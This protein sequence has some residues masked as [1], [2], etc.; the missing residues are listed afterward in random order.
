[1]KTRADFTEVSSIIPIYTLIQYNNR[2]QC[3][4]A[5][6]TTK[7]CNK[8]IDFFMLEPTRGKNIAGV[9]LQL[10]IGFV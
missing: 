10:R 9:N 4:L 7:T 3:Y 5:L 2:F 8:Q 6:C 1:M